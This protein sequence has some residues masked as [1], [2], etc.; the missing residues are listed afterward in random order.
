[1]DEGGDEEGAA[2]EV[3]EEQE[4]MEACVAP[5]ESHLN[6]VVLIGTAPPD[7]EDGGHQA[8]HG[9]L[10]IVA[11]E[12]GEHGD[13]P[14]VHGCHEGKGGRHHAQEGGCVVA[15]GG[16]PG[17]VLNGL[18]GC[19]HGSTLRILARPLGVPAVLLGVVGE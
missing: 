13:G 1:M 10:A 3:E 9:N 18:R 17:C 16:P 7:A 12:E 2:D 5:L 15:C 11:E 19:L 14:E 4:V 6:L 8:A